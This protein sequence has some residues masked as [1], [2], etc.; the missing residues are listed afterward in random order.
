MRIKG[1]KLSQR[2]EFDHSEDVGRLLFS[3]DEE[4]LVSGAGDGVRIWGVNTG[5]LLG[6]AAAG[7]DVLA[8]GIS[9][10]NGQI[11]AAFGK[12]I[13]LYTRSGKEKGKVGGVISNGARALAYSADGSRL[14]VIGSDRKV[15]LINAADGKALW[16]QGRVA[17]DTAVALSP[18]G[19]LALTNFSDGK[20]KGLST[21]DG[22]EAWFVKGSA[23]VGVIAAGGKIM[24]TPG[25]NS[26]VLLWRLR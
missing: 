15:H 14:L 20:L 16:S 4:V 11:A 18:D 12:E 8:I 7:K 24:A 9:P 23:A 21:T 22:S 3:S 2:Y 19:K 17:Y 26:T 1:R 6:K 13:H 25:A 5:E 10:A